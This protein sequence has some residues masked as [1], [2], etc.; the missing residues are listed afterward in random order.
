MLASLIQ[1]TYTSTKSKMVFAANH[2]H[3]TRGQVDWNSSSA[4]NGLDTSSS[5][6]V[7]SSMQRCE[8]EVLK[9][10]RQAAKR[11][12]PCVRQKAKKT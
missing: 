9:F 8:L 2:C 3:C 1:T 5:G 4:S 7:P 12:P 10:Q 11:R 6:R